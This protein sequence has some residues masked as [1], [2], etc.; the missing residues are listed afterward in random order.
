MTQLFDENLACLEEHHPELHA[1]IAGLEI[2]RETYRRTES[3]NNLP[4]LEV[5][6]GKGR[7]VALHSLH[8][9]QREAERMVEPLTERS[10]TVPVFLGLGMGYGPYT[11][12][13]RHRE[14][15]FDLL[16]IESDLQVF[17]AALETMPLGGMLRDPRVHWAV[18]ADVVELRRLIRRLLPGIMSTG[19]SLMENRGA[20]QIS[21]NY[22]EQVAALIQNTLRHTASEFT[23]MAQNGP[24]LQLNVWRNFPF[25]LGQPGLRDAAGSWA[26]RPGILVGA[27]PSLTKNVD[28][29]AEIRDEVLIVCVDTAYRVLEARKIEPHIVVATDPTQ[30][31]AEHFQNLTLQG[32][33][34]LAFDPEVFQILPREIPWRKLVLNLE[35]SD[36]TRWMEE[37]A[38][39]WGLY[40]KGG[41]VA[42][43]AWSI[44]ETLG[45]DPVIL[46][47]MDLAF[48][49]GGGT[50][51]AEGTALSRPL[52]AIADQSQDALLGPHAATD[53]SLKEEL[54]WVPGILGGNVP[55]SP[56]MA[57]YIH[58]FQELF[59]RGGR[60]MIDA[61]EGGALKQGTEIKSLSQA[62]A[63]LGQVEQSQQSPSAA[64]AN[65][66]EYAQENDTATIARAVE[67]IAEQLA[68][69]VRSA[70][71]AITQS[72][73]LAGR[74][75]Q[76]KRVYER[77]EWLEMEKTFQEIYRNPAVKIALEQALFSV[78]YFF[79]QKEDPAQV[80]VRYEKY[81][82]YF[83]TLVE[84]GRQFLPLLEETAQ[85][86]RMTPRT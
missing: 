76:G 24:L 14:R 65:L 54:K 59:S 68:G 67:E 50:T 36:T 21:G 13:T 26:G 42:H 49:P 25:M 86:I 63:G 20:D 73:E 7:P 15:F 31:E 41:S 81:Q 72:H 51:H 60:R 38:G 69:G 35:K 11:A 12:W 17:C 28:Q 75:N 5:H 46:M 33:P 23:Y 82:K 9:P 44:L 71:E 8:N 78:T 18:D 16:V 53:E 85:R 40:D 55:T 1:K 34:L 80:S 4:T 83:T 30:L 77:P 45:A 3:R 32:N 57:L 47:G 37:T 61:T 27:G 10:L 79:A 64:L 84:T 70:E 29:L 56:I 43:T 66:R 58:T 62:L 74:M 22:Y 52:E 6:T 48:P 19:L 39:P 2:D